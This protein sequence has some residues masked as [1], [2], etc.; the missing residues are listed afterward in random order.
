MDKIFTD[1]LRTY[2]DQ[3]EDERNI[4][5]GA[6]LLLQLD[7]NQ[8]RFKSIVRH[9]NIP[10]YRNMLF[11]RLKGHLQRRLDGYTLEEV[12]RMEPVADQMAAAVKEVAVVDE[13]DTVI[14]HA[15]KR[16]DHDQLPEE[17]RLKYQEN[18]AIMTKM[19][20]LHAQIS[21]LRE[22]GAAPC[23]LYEHLKQLLDLDDQRLQNWADYD[24][25]KVVSTGEMPV[26]N[27]VDNQ[28]EEQPASAADNEA[29]SEADKDA[30]EEPSSAIKEMQSARSYISRNLAALEALAEDETKL[31]E[32]TAKKK[33]MQER[34]A[35]LVALGSNVKDE[36][37]ARL[38]KLGITA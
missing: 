13:S 8:S 19:R 15:G 4:E 10:A 6:T 23:D 30:T 25:A 32:F 11:D 31:V 28:A 16:A 29:A 37:V 27:S 12:K 21:L 5:Q 18:L 17:A 24:G 20:R 14:A 3:P 33:A 22:Q 1:K 2:L 35:R 38:N 26:D 36:T 7:R 9:A 34:Y